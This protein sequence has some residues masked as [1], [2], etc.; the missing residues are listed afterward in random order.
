MLFLALSAL[1]PTCAPVRL[2]LILELFPNYVRA[3]LPNT[4]AAAGSSKLGQKAA[5]S[6]MPRFLRSP[7]V[8]CQRLTLHLGSPLH[9]R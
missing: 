2:S 1:T 4:H 9:R 8:L 7:L 6:L 3:A 5:H